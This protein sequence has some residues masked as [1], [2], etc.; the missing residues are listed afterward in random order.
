[1]IF[2]SAAVAA[3]PAYDSGGA[4]AVVSTR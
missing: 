1:M 4:G 3:T 2:G